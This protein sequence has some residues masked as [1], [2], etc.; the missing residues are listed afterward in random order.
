M[1]WLDSITDSM[2]M[3]WGKFTFAALGVLQ[4]MRSQRVRQGLVTQ[5]QQHR[6]V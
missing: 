3:K 4:F 5:L 2:D 6:S 1:R